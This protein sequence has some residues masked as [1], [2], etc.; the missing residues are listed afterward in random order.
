M[1]IKVDAHLTL[2]T[3]NRLTGPLVQHEG[4]V[5]ASALATLKA[6]K[7]ELPTYLLVILILFLITVRV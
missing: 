2:E 4:M 7:L 5:E 1:E 6:L 3:I